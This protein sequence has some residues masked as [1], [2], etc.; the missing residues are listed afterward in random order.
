MLILLF[1]SI[2]K[3]NGNFFGICQGLAVL[4]PSSVNAWNHGLQI[5][6]FESSK[7]GVNEY[8]AGKQKRSFNTSPSLL[9]YTQS[10]ILLSLKDDIQ[11]NVGRNEIMSENLTGYSTVIAQIQHRNEML[12]DENNDNNKQQDKGQEQQLL[13]FLQDTTRGTS[14][15]VFC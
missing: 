2:F 11:R 12:P 5:N 7:E 13:M 1:A 10:S 15:S 9:S 14:S 8:I 4:P 3:W 6:F